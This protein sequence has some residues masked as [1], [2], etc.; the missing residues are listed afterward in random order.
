VAFFITEHI[1]DPSRRQEGEEL[2]VEVTIPKKGPPRPIRL[3]VKK[4]EGPIIPLAIK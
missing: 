4:S 1:T 3:G 2:W